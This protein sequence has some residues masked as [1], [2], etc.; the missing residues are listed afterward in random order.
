MRKYLAELHKKPDH[1]KKQFALLASGTITLFIFGVWSLATFGVNSN[2][3]VADNNISN[4]ST[5]SESE[6]GPLQ[7]FGSSVASSWEAIKNSFGQLQ[8]G[9]KTINFDTEYQEMKDGA[10]KTYGQ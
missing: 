8:D 3:V 9:L 2:G 6:M 1:H 10:L 7:S 4:V 5:V